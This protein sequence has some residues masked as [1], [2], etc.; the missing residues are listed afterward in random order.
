MARPNRNLATP[1]EWNPI[2]TG[3]VGGN[4]SLVAVVGDIASRVIIVGTLG[5]LV[6][7]NVD[8]SSTIFTAAQIAAAGNILY[9]QF[10]QVTAAGSTAFDLQVGL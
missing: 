3:A 2:W 6:V 10:T 8:G 4:T 1:T 7:V 9:G 5:S